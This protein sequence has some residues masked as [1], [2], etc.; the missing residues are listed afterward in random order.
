MPTNAKPQTQNVRG[1]YFAPWEKSFDLI[2]TPFEV[3]IHRQTTSGL[4]L[5]A[6]TILALVLANSIFAAFYHDFTHIPVAVSAGKWTLEKTLYHWVNDA[7]MA[8]FFF[9]VGLELKR[10][11]LVG[12]LAS[13]RKAALPLI[14]AVGGM[15]VPALIY[16][17][18]NPDGA[19]S[20]GWA[21]PMATDIAFAIG[22]MVLLGNR[23]PKALMAFLVAL[24]IAD[25]LAA[26][27]VIALFYTDTIVVEALWVAAAITGIL[28]IFNFSGVRWEIPYFLVA[29]LLWFAM[30]YSGVHPTLAGV[31]GAFTVPARPKYNPEYFSTKMKDLT[32]G[33]DSSYQADQKITTNIAMLATVQTMENLLHR[34]MTPLQRLEHIWHLPVAYLVLPVFAFFNAGI[35]LALGM[36]TENGIHPVMLGIVTGL[37]AGKFIGITGG[38]WIALK[39]GIA[40]LPKDT[41]FSQLAGAALLAGIGFTM[42][43]FIAQLSFEEESSLL[44][45]AKTS[46][47]SASIISGI[48]GFI[49]LWAVDKRSKRKA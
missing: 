21:I 18:F 44:L 12:E 26:V 34:V 1:I 9:V 20:K 36:L 2:F 17:F 14:A 32:A 47:L 27:T 25:D 28:I 30:L 29:V 4:L 19:A 48:S 24:A 49:W 3:F 13:L 37:V 35:P 10:E 45:I 41:S 16:F 23:V 15:V 40:Q 43:I 46:I 7:L 38:C 33:F 8:F 6:T 22:A 11:L 31:I 5:V 42:S 39:L